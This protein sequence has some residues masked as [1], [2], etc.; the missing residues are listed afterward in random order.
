MWPIWWNIVSAEE[1]TD[2]SVLHWPV[3]CPNGLGCGP[4]TGA[5]TP[6][7]VQRLSVR[8]SDESSL[9]VSW[10]R[11]EGEYDLL[12]AAVTQGD[13]VV[14]ER[15]LPPDSTS[16]SFSSLVP[17][18]AYTVTVRT[19]RGNQSSSSSVSA[20]TA[21]AQ[22]S[23]L[24]LSNGGSTDSL[25]AQWKQPLGAVDWYQVLLV[26]DSSIIKN[27]TVSSNTTSLMFT[28]LKPGAEYRAVL[29]TRRG[30]REGR[31]SVGE[32]RTVPAAVGEVTVS[33]NGRMDFLSVSW[34]P[35][36][37]EVD[38]YLV[39]L[40]DKERT[41]HTLVVSR[42][43]PECVFKSLVPGR[44]YHISISSRSGAYENSSTVQGRTQPS[45]VQLLT[46]THAARDRYLK[47]YWSHARGDLDSYEVSIKHNAQFVHNTSVPKTEREC[48]FEGLEPGRLYTVLVNTRSG[49]YET[50]ASTDG[51]TL[52]APVR[53]LSLS[54]STSDSLV[55]SWLSAPGEVDHYEVQ[56]VYNDIKVFPPQTL[57]SSM[58][59]CTLSS[60]T[61]G[62]LYKILVSTFSGP[63]QRA[64]FIQGRTVPGQVKN[65]HVSNGGDS[66][67]LKVSWSSAVGDVDSYWVYLYRDTRLL[68]SRPVHKDQTQV[69]FQSLQ[70]GQK[71]SLVVQ[72]L[73]GEL[74][75]NRTEG[76]EGE[77]GSLQRLV[78]ARLKPSVLRRSGG[79]LGESSGRVR[80]LQSDSTD[81]KGGAVMN[82]SVPSA[83]THH[84]FESLTPGKSYRVL[85]QT[86]SGAERSPA[87]SAQGRT[88]P[89]AASDLSLRSSSSSSLSFSWSA[90]NGE[91]DGFEMFLYRWDDS[92]QE[93]RRQTPEFSSAPSQT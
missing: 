7:P 50:S 63:N 77:E 71:Y 91:F 73:S 43:S 45:P 56:L 89:A 24:L 26:Q 37:G 25:Q 79:E 29:T 75:D 64:V 81:E 28:G 88:C 34:R 93:R 87:A 47:V 90:P 4:Y 61:P 20:R 83:R 70:P 76:P 2:G 35:P 57:G 31:Q 72:T 33:N 32:G 12:T 82:V 38:S 41:V 10:S 30:G 67:S 65:I 27:Q 42:S 3:V 23:S 86:Q 53:S 78:S 19:N 16:V 51:R 55:V 22:V 60:L 21:P 1:I 48:A 68:D 66:S 5:T 9:S 36:V 14:F 15:T 8:H 17:G 52:P 92:V 13:A 85:I 54:S 46:A 74:D 49:E 44:L 39:L 80:Q 40:R 18:Q 11:P 59:R 6:A 84:R 58:D 62:R 69:H